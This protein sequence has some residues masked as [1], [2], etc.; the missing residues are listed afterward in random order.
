MQYH[1]LMKQKHE[2]E[3]KQAAEQAA[4]RKEI[5][6][7]VNAA[8][9]KQLSEEDKEAAAERAAQELI[10]AEERERDSKKAFSGSGTV[11]KGF[12]DKKKKK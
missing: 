2:M 9:Q 1:N 10:K 12:L 7:R 8:K 4:K 11:K 3:Q 5:E 6:E